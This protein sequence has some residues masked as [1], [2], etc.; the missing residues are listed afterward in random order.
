MNISD[1]LANSIKSID[2]INQIKAYL[3]QKNVQ[4][5]ARHLLYFTLGI[6]TCFKP[7][8]MINLKWSDI[9][10]NG[11]LVEY[12]EYNNFHFYLNRSCKNAINEYTQKYKSQY[13]D[14]YV[15]STTGRPPVIQTINAVLGNIERDLNLG[16]NL[17]SLSLFKTF[18]YWQI[19][20]CH[21]DYIKM[22]KLEQITHLAAQAKN[23]TSFA[24]YPICNDNI[25][26]NDVNL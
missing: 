14:T 25:Y 6:N 13:I 21:N 3:K 17:S 2:T 18:V 16:Y 11:I 8:F 7:S 15:F 9:F 10:H 24:E 4:P 1:K 19:Y 12:I 20:Y 22:V 5:Y 23:L 26:I